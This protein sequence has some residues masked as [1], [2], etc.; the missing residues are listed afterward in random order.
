[1]S[2]GHAPL[3]LGFVAW[4]GTGKTTLL[5]ALLPLLVGAGLRVGIV[6]HAHHGFDIDQP[7]KDSHRLRHAG[8]ARVLVASRQRWALM[9][10]TPE[11]PEANLARAIEGLG[12]DPL[13]VVLVEGFKHER[14]TK[15]EVHRP[16]L[17]KPLM[18]PDDEDI[19]A[20]VSDAP[21]VRATTLP[22]L[23]LNQPAEVAA[24]LFERAG[25][26]AAASA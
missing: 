22:L 21:L 23:D 19:V 24:F 17:G 16:S 20:V 4:S 1:M 13:D 25:I 3:V 26:A 18:F 11:L 8:A 14:Y 12:A 6:K 9:V 7:G 15:V 5:E 10:E 2:A